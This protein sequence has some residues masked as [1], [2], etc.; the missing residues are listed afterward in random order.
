[1]QLCSALE[2]ADRLV[3]SASANVETL[4]EKLDTL[5][6]IIKRGDAA[7]DQAK[8][9]LSIQNNWLFD[10]LPANVCVRKESSLLFPSQSCMC[11]ILWSSTSLR[12][13]CVLSLELL[14]KA[15]DDTKLSFMLI[16]IMFR[17][18]V[19]HF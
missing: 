11:K 9:V 2:T 12:S 4:K 7:V 6:H 16:K 10:K 3:Q 14:A 1:M 8:A 19:F 5:E 13:V 18:L 15:L 17:I